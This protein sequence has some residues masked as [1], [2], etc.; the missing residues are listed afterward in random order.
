LSL[1]HIS[2]FPS[3]IITT[4]I[5]I[6]SVVI[7][8]VIVSPTT[9]SSLATPSPVNFVSHHH[10]QII[11]SVIGFSWSLTSSLSAGH[12]LSLIFHHHQFLHQ[13]A[14]AFTPSSLP[15]SSAGCHRLS[16]IHQY[17]PPIISQSSRLAHT[18]SSGWPIR[19]HWFFV[20]SRASHHQLGLPG[21]QHGSSPQF[22]PPMFTR[23]AIHHHY[24]Q[25]SMV[26]AHSPP[27]FT[28]IPSGCHRHHSSLSPGE[29]WLPSSAGISHRQSVQPSF[30]RQS[31]RWPGQPNGAATVASVFTTAS[32]QP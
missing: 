21:D 18:P 8:R 22:P 15:P 29:G 32:N 2:W 24:H 11:S 1:P 16:T 25:L 19:H 30:Q 26:I 28:P 23:L 31:G 13:A 10:C 14:I 9:S 6:S 27:V 3:V 7:N 17:T 4:T 5:T 12:Y 20:I